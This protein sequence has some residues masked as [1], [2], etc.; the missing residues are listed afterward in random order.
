[1]TSDMAVIHLPS[2]RVG[3]VL[4]G[5]GVRQAGGDRVTQL[6]LLAHVDEADAM[7]PPVEVPIVTCS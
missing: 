3:P 6:R 4:V 1:M 2:P 7:E 5:F